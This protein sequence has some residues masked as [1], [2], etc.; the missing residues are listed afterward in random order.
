MN[1]VTL[2]LKR[3]FEDDKYGSISSMVKVCQ[4]IGE[5]KRAVLKELNEGFELEC[6]SFAECAAV[7]REGGIDADFNDGSGEYP[8]S[9]IFT[10]Q[11][12][13]KGEEFN[14]VEIDLENPEY[15]YL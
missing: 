10:W 7:L 1:N 15:Q 13:G 2:V 3:V 12:N 5:A 11:D 9:F 6:G 14:I 4:S 8:D